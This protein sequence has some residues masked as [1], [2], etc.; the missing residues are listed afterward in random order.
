MNEPVG[1]SMTAASWLASAQTAINAIRA[2]GATNHILVPSTYWG[3]PINFVQLNASTMINVTDPA[4]NYSYDVH[5]YLD[6]DGSGRGTD[7]LSPADAVAT[8]SGFTA[9]AKANNRKAFLSEIGVSKDAGPRASLSAMLQYMHNNSSVWKGYTYWSAGP[10]WQS[11]IFGV[12]PTNNVDTPQMTT[13]IANPAP[14]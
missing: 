4:N 11:Y 3:H 14:R 10:W 8:L 13:L 9:W 6:S 2:T 12:Q 5:Q 1:S 7:A